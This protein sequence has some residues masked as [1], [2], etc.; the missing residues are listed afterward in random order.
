MILD[1][2]KMGMKV[3]GEPSSFVI[4]SDI[5]IKAIERPHGRLLLHYT[6][7][8]GLCLVAETEKSVDARVRFNDDLIRFTES[9]GEP[10]RDDV[11]Q[12]ARVDDAARVV[13]WN[14]PIENEHHISRL[15]LLFIEFTP[16]TY[17]ATAYF[18]NYPS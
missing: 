6:P 9:L 4:S 14:E 3:E 16:G 17:Q 12:W 2:Y 7:K 5:L 11:I 1:E 10:S 8:G 15:E 13:R 18:A